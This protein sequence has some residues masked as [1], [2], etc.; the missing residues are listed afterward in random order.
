MAPYREASPEQAAFLASLIEAGLLLDTGAPGLLG[1][2]PLF[3]DV[4]EAF[5][6][7]VTRTSGS[8]PV[9]SMRFPP[10]TSTFEIEKNGYLASFPHL[11]GR[12]FSFEGNDA[13][14][15]EL[16]G[17]AARHEDW[18]E[19]QSKTDAVLLPAA[20]YPVYPQVA[21]R[22]PLPAGGV[23]VDTGSAWVFRNE[24]SGDPAA[25]ALVPH[26]RVRPDRRSR[27]CRDVPRRLAR[28]DARPVRR[29]GLVAESEVASD[30]FFGRVGR[31][32][33]ANQKEQELKFELVAMVGG[34]EPTA[35]ASFNYH[36]DHFTQVYDIGLE[37]GRIAHTGCVAFG[38]ERVTLALFRAHGLDPQTWPSEVRAELWP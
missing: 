27:R 19:F 7:A 31:M 10:L 20:C 22:G 25:D 1:Q 37:G 34:P 26:A 13:Q 11:A 33:A 32:L 15:L 30:P 2:G 3:D 12:V 14:A 6:T 16:E 17:R 18:S 8:D 29:L 38:I 9:E 23:I 28:A 21:R 35:I 36:Q 4:R 24:P 5:T